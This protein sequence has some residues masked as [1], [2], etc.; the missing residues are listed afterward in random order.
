MREP[1]PVTRRPGVD[2]REGVGTACGTFGELLQGSLSDGVDFLVTFPISRGT[3]AWFRYDHDGPL[4]VFPSHKTKSL[5]VARAMLD[6]Q[7]AGG[8]SLVLDSGLAVGKGLASSSADLV[9][10]VRAVGEVLG[11]DTSPAAT[12]DWLRPIEP[13]DGVMHPGVVVFEHRTVRLRASL[14][15]LP[16]A[17][18]V[19]VDE[20]GRLD[21]VAYNRRPHR[22][23]AA[24]RREYE[25]LVRDLAA[26]VA[27]GDL[28]RVGA[29]ATR[30]AVLNQRLLP[31]RNLDAMIR[32][33]DEIGALGVVCAHSGTM[34]GLLLDAGDPDHRHKL[35]AASAACS[36]LPGA[37]TV[38]RSFTSPGSAH[39][40]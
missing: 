40:L 31:K 15:T 34:L 14:G 26:A 12:E 2:L 36:R 19:A 7:G 22:R 21:T 39:A 33:G 32:V 24:Q 4:S 16:P 8:G 35:L 17:T 9:A 27:H 10:T 30:S 3:R 1:A 25:R 5:R 37:T 20:G 23:T 11:V 13:T 18:V 38:F 29:V 6:A 28:A